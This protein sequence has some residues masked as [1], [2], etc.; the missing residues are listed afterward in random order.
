[1]KKL[2]KSL[3]FS[4]LATFAVSGCNGL[5][6][7]TDENGTQ[8][9]NIDEDT[10][11]E[12]IHEIYNLYAVS[13]REEGKEPLSYEDWL[14][15]IKGEKG[16]QG[17]KGNDG[18][19]LHA[20]S[21]EPSNNLGIVGDS[22]IDLNSW[23]FYLKT[24]N[25]WAKQ[26]NIKGASGDH[27]NTIEIIRLKNSDGLVDTYEIILSDASSYTFQ[28]ING[29]QGIQGIRGEKG[30]DGH[31]PVITIGNNGNWYIDGGDTGFLAEARPAPT[32]V[33]MQL[34]NTIENREYYT[35]YYS[36]GSN[37]T[38]YVINGTN[39]EMGIQGEKGDDGHTPVITISDEG[40]WV[41]D[42]VSTSKY[43]LGLSPTIIDGW[44]YLGDQPLNVKASGD[45]GH[46]PN[47]Y[48]NNDGYWEVDGVSTGVFARGSQ[49]LNGK[50]GSMIFSGTSTQY[51]NNARPGDLYFNTDSMH[52]YQYSENNSND[53]Y[54]FYYWNDLGS[55]KGAD[56]TNITVGIDFPNN[57]KVGDICIIAGTWELYKYQSTP[58]DETYLYYWELQGTIKGEKATEQLHL[59]S[60]IAIN[61]T[62]GDSSSPNKPRI[63]DLNTESDLEFSVRFGD[64]FGGEDYLYYCYQQFRVKVEGSDFVSV[65]NLEYGQPIS[66]PGRYDSNSG[67]LTLHIN[68]SIMTGETFSVTITSAYN[69]MA[70]ATMYYKVMRYEK[71]DTIEFP[72]EVKI[73]KEWEYN[74]YKEIFDFATSKNGVKE[75]INQK[76]NAKYL[77][78]GN[79]SYSFSGSYQDSQYLKLYFD[80]VG[81]YPFR[82]Y[83]VD[84]PDIYKD[85]N[86]CIC[87]KAGIENAEI[88][89]SYTNGVGHNIYQDDSTL[90]Y[91]EFG[92]VDVRFSNDNLDSTEKLF[93]SYNNT[94]TDNFKVVVDGQAI[95]LGYVDCNYRYEYGQPIYDT[96]SIA[97][98]GVKKGQ[99]TLKVLDMNDN[100]LIS[101]TYTVVSSAPSQYNGISIDYNVAYEAEYSDP[102]TFISPFDNFAD[103]IASFDV[104]IYS[105]SMNEEVYCYYI[106]SDGIHF[107]NTVHDNFNIELYRKSNHELY[108]QYSV[109]RPAAPAP[110]LYVIDKDYVY[111]YGESISFNDD[112][113]NYNVSV[114]RVFDGGSES[115]IQN[116]YVNQNK[117]YIDS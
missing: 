75:G 3:V 61:S 23:D 72:D 37:F 44:W 29:S 4:I 47:V 18:T 64:E 41:I 56:G 39:G 27:G 38:F 50:D 106:D 60:F 15:L 93:L 2:F 85:I 94:D 42:G 114:F 52:V 24:E 66:E 97:V 110:E 115:Q 28:V 99:S 86:V 89:D 102:V 40:Y 10:I 63:I 48:I 84:Y 31:T 112:I 32:V 74:N 70:T 113:S 33:D 7:N 21:G 105:Q 55:T 67:S 83:S 116:Y 6:V 90:L 58:M 43:A 45:N 100:V 16:D 8:I 81:V 78:E 117:I 54:I 9:I 108:G 107:T 82:I 65:S 49:G 91:G 22:Y 62:I 77:G 17:E 96:A 95:A 111:E 30:D 14:E 103:L 98:T 71:P 19:S 13:E 87:E 51:P 26:G 20:A 59:P 92:F 69:S 68:N 101:K 1:M 109:F 34:T 80:E 11:N 46:T 25:G 79:K 53:G 5:S 73:Y 88:V 12:K 36:D 76:L 35:V 104:K 57:P